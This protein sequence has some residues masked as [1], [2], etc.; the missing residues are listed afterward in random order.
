[1]LPLRHVSFVVLKEEK[2]AE[3]SHFRHE[4]IF[5]SFLFKL[6]ISASKPLFLMTV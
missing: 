1:M 6:V 5:S 2:H 3:R 4:F